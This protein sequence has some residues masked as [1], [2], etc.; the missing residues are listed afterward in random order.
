M[1]GAG[2]N[3]KL[4]SIQRMNLPLWVTT[5]SDQPQGR[6]KERQ[7]SGGQDHPMLFLSH[8]I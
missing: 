1:L 2:E 4:G 8:S 7:P 3:L 6:Q 5:S